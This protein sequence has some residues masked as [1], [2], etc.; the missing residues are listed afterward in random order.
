MQTLRP[1]AARCPCR[2]QLG[3]HG[4]CVELCHGGGELGYHLHIGWVRSGVGTE[5]GKIL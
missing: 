5:S 1:G 4:V 2:G 3:Q